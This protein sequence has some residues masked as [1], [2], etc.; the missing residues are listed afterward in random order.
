MFF[1]ETKDCERHRFNQ[2]Y[3]TLLCVW[4]GTEKN[5]RPFG[6]T[7]NWQPTDAEV[8]ELC[9]RMTKL[10]PTF[11]E[12]LLRLAAEIDIPTTPTR[13]PPITITDKTKLEVF[14]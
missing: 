13:N 6:F 10:S 12:S 14:L 8:I 4:Q 9:E 2:G 5:I 7:G 3:V 11:K 1:V